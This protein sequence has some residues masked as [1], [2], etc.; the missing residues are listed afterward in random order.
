[1]TAPLSGVLV[2]DKPAGPTS[3]DVVA[4]VKK[5]LRVGR[6]G[7]TGTLDPLATGV[8]PV[9]VGKATRLARFLSAGEKSYRAT[10]RLGFATSTD[11]AEGEPLGPRRPLELLPASLEHACG[12]LRGEIL[13]V[14]PMFSARHVAGRRLYEWAR[15]GVAV[16]R[17]PA[18]VT[19][20]ALDVVEIRGEEVELEVRCSAGTYVRA[21][22][23]DLGVALECGGHL[24]AL[25][26]TSSGG[27]G[28]EGSVT[29]DEIGE[30]CLPRLLALETLLPELP[31]VWVNAEGREAV[32]HGR[33]VTPRHLLRGGPGP[34][35]SRVRLMD[36]EGRLLA[37]ALARGAEPAEPRE[38]ELRPD[39][40][41]MD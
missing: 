38:P 30:A 34:G 37:L 10:V 17:P 24:S 40:V 32:R 21:L 31:A 11:D 16:T 14:P 9:C 7:H 22:A 23:R 25:R 5:A 41:L 1:M 29:W 15:E 12:G 13:Q 28:L 27:L 33:A 26:R 2:V 8:L 39:V 4:R 35:V 3:H 6:A 36:S 18:R 20:Y 19:V